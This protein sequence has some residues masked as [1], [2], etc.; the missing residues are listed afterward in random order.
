MLGQL[1][2]WLRMAGYDTLYEPDIED[3]EVLRL[4][5]L[6]DRTILTRD[7]R[8]AIRKAALGRSFLIES[9]DPAE[10]LRQVILKF[11]PEAGQKSRCPVC[12]G[13][14]RKVVKKDRVRDLV[15]EHVFLGFGRFYR[16]ASCGKVYWE[17]SHHAR[18]RK[19]LDDIIKKGEK[20]R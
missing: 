7:R 17:G 20:T 13:L 9:E 8:L 15:P 11:P 3:R 16:C 14:L 4:A 18:L 1:A 2:R 5:R 6:E 10:Q 12:N 19:T